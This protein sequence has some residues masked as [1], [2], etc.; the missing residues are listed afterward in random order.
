[1]SFP[2]LSVNPNFPIEEGIEPSSIKS[3]FEAGYVL[4]RAKFTRERNNFKLSYSLLSN[5]DKVLLKDHMDSVL[6]IT[7]FNWTHPITSVTYSVR[8]QTIP[9]FQYVQYNRW[10][11]GFIL[12]QL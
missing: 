4:A 5:A 3:T 7:P 6:D 12:E 1:M 8:Y 9:A 10:S 11:I 2:T